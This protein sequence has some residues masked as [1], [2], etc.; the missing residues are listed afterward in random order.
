MKVF[1]S[2]FQIFAPIVHV[3]DFHR[4]PQALKRLMP[5]PIILQ[6]HR[7]DPLSEQSIAEFT[8]WIGPFPVRWTAIHTGVNPLHGFTDIQLKGPMKLWQHT[9]RFTEMGENI[10]LVQDHIQFDYRPGFR[11]FW[12]Q[13]LYAPLMLRILFFYRFLITR[14]EVLKIYKNKSNAQNTEESEE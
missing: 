13:I 7:I 1:T 2:Q 3:A 12:T 9:H 4:S 14:H 6:F 11:Y 8:I 10:T 5:F